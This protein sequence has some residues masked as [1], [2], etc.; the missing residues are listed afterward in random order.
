MRPV[1]SSAR[2]GGR[3]ADARALCLISHCR[4]QLLLPERQPSFDWLRSR[5]ISPPEETLFEKL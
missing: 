5:K 2:R 4:M 1:L 3:A